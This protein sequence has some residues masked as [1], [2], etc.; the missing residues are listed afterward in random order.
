M[1]ARQ[2]KSNDWMTAEFESGKAKEVNITKTVCLLLEATDLL[3][4]FL[5]SEVSQL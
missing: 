3:A 2:T 1:E 4:M 5:K